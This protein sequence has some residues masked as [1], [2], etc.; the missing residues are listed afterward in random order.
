M[1]FIAQSR[2]LLIGML[3]GVSIRVTMVEATRAA[4]RA[5]TRIIYVTHYI[6]ENRIEHLP[7]ALYTKDCSNSSV[8]PS[9]EVAA[10]VWVQ[11]VPP[12]P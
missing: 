12:A 7:K 9:V 6:H 1:L 2:P 8:A 5:S 4:K 11:Q 3:Y 10:E